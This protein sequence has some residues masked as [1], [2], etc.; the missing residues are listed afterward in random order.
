MKK[1]LFYL[2][3]MLC[4]IGLFV[5]C[6]DDDDPVIPDPDEPEVPVV[7]ESWKD[8]SKTYKVSENSITLT[9]IA[10]A[11]AEKEVTVA[12]SSATAATVTLKNIVPDA[13]GVPVTVTMAKADDTYTLSGNAVIGDCTV[14]VAGSIDGS[15][16]MKLD[17]TRTLA[18]K[19]TG[20]LPLL[21]TEAEM[22]PGVKVPFVPVHWVAT[23]GDATIDAQ[24]A[25]VGQML[26]GLI[27]S[28]VSAVNVALAA[29]G[30]FNV[31]WTKLGE[32]EPTGMPPMIA[33]L[34]GNIYY[35]VN[36]GVLFI[37]LD[38]SIIGMLDMFSDVVEAFGIDIQKILGL[39]QDLGGYKGLPLAFVQAD[40]VTTFKMEKEQILAIMD[41]L[42]PTLV[43]SLPENMAQLGD[44][45]N[46]LPMAQQLELGLPFI[47][48]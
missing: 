36:D 37:A 28:K 15:K 39:M 7:D 25:V 35:T 12:A 4:S 41:I 8:L 14:A 38:N 9:G 46:V 45:L 33:A 34:I 2:F 27:P 3:A 32:S 6:G 22:M 19:V 42:G 11:G 13:P 18:S 17:V 1:N 40:G 43:E 30:T 10:M 21:I 5:A 20:N 24:L 26:G 31:N 16:K 44:L 29:N 23:T 47:N 48:Q